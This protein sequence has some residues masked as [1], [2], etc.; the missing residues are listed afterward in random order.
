MALLTSVLESLRGGHRAEIREVDSL[1]NAADTLTSIGGVARLDL[2]VTLV[3]P[4][5]SPRVTHDVVLNT[6]F[7]SISD[8]IDG[9]VDLRAAA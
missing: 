9:V 7:D 4:F 1:V 2:D 5:N 8:S 6:V 3:A